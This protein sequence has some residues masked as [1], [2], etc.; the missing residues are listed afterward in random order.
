MKGE[1]PKTPE[2]SAKYCETEK[3]KTPV[4]H[5]VSTFDI[6]N[7]MFIRSKFHFGI[8]DERELA[9]K[10]I[11]AVAQDVYYK[12]EP[13]IWI[14]DR[15]FPSLSLIQKLLEHR[16]YF[17]MRV[18]SSFLKEVNAFRKSK[19]V[20]R[21]I[22]IEYSEHRATQNHV[23]S[24]GIS[25]FDLRCVRVKLPSGEDEILVTNLDRKDFPK[26]DIKEI[27]RLRWGIETGFNYLKMPYS[28][29]NLSQKLKTDLHKTILCRFSFTICNLHMWQYVSEYPKKR[30]YKYKINRRT[31]T[32][33]IY[34]NLMDVLFKSIPSL[35]R[36]LNALKSDIIK[37]L[38]PVR[39]NRSF[40]RHF[41]TSRHSACHSRAVLS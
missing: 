1:L 26:R 10:M 9:G 8:A 25:Q 11:D 30:K 3:C 4:F 15:G 29:R 27:Y 5:A 18:S 36:V 31:A 39:P 13:Q 40:P 7:E 41:D 38:S 2:L 35:S 33:L 20:D 37:H 21:V 6:L 24:D 16:L 14:F 28:W 12:D 19:Y 22:H 32:R 34:H 17:V 23:H